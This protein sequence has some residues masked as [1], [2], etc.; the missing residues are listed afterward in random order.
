VIGL[1]YWTYSG[2]STGIFSDNGFRKISSYV[3]ESFFKP[4]EIS[5]NVFNELG[6]GLED[7]DLR[8]GERHYKTG[9]SG[10]FL[11]PILPTD[12]KIFL[13][14]RGYLQKEVDIDG[15]GELKIIMEKESPGIAFR[16]LRFIYR[17]LK[18]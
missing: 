18:T 17:L 5:G 8:I 9:S 3:L 15:V 7:V 10:N 4:K 14:K 12:K 6:F 11:I 13:Q 1:N 2:G 16:F